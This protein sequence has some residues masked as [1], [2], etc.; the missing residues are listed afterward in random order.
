[1][2]KTLTTTQHWS[3]SSFGSPPDTSPMELAALGDHLSRCTGQRGSFFKLKC[4]GDALNDFAAPRLMTMLALF[5]LASVAAT[6]V[7]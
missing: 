2:N 6:L 5:V 4:A 7:I 1:M 3:T